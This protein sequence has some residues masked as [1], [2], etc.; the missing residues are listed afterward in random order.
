MALVL[1]AFPVS[2]AGAEAVVLHHGLAVRLIPSENKLTGIDEM[3]VRPEG[4]ALLDFV[5]SKRA[6]VKA[7]EVN[8]SPKAYVF[9]NGNLRVLLEADERISVIKVNIKYQGTFNDPVP[10]MPVNTDNPGYGV[11]GIISEKGSFLLSGAGWYPEIPGSRPTFRLKVDAPAGVIAVS[12]GELSGHETRGE[13]TLSAWTVKHPV[14]GLSLSAARYQV[15]EKPAGRVK[16]MTY[17]LAENA[18]LSQGYLDAVVRY[19]ADY[20]TLF[21]PYPFDKFAVAEN[22]FP[23]GYG[24]PS[25]T[26]LGGRVIRL[27]FIIHTSLGHEIAH[28]WWGNGVY[29][30]YAKGNWC[31][32]LTTYVS[33]YRFKEK[34][35]NSAAR[36]YRLQLLRNYATL[37][38][39]NDDFPLSRFHSRYDPAT[40]TIG[41]DKGAMV[42]HM[43]RVRLGE[44]A[45]WGALRDIYRD[46]LFQRVSWEDLRAAFERRGS[47]SFEKFFAQWV[48]R[49]GAARLSLEGVSAIRSGN[50]WKVTGRVVQQGSLYDLRLK[51]KLETDDHKV[52]SEL[53]LSEKHTAFEIVA[54]KPPKRLSVDPDADIFRALSPP[55]IPPQVNSLKG[56]SSVL[57][58]LA[59]QTSSATRNAAGLLVQSLGLK[60]VRFVLEDD[61]RQDDVN[62]NDLLLAGFPVRKDLFSHLPE[63]LSI[64]ESAFTLNGN[65]YDRP[66]D[67]FFGVLNHP[68]RENGV[69]G[70]FLPLS[71]PFAETVAR[72]I[73]HYGQYSYLVFRGETNQDKGTWPIA[74]SPLVYEW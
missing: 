6:K 62:G 73:T 50:S 65:R 14:D 31:E 56:S 13:R 22:F 2:E 27:P 17:M 28:C 42:F 16:A 47:C 74:S 33:D 12:A 41:Y 70:V 58:V 30:D 36:E 67:V 23:T 71:D 53:A 26:L 24:F 57:V 55:E 43:L 18:H 9:E 3:E 49:K 40:K 68:S 19:I 1:A 46:K 51:L 45:F 32:G 5:L 66:S 54:D 7:V 52:T 37:I 4:S 10:V 21:G 38:K 48:Y 61:V 20:E 11:T 63:Q 15:R 34:V 29:A 69:M 72:K 39:P 64:S 60:Q 25:Y 59:G 44:A 8:D 35:S